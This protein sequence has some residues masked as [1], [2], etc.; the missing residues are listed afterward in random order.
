MSKFWSSKVRWPPVI[1]S[2]VLSTNNFIQSKTKACNV[3]ADRL[4]QLVEYRTTVRGPTLRVCF[5]LLLSC[6]HVHTTPNNLIS[7]SPVV[8]TSLHVHLRTKHDRKITNIT[9]LNYLPSGV[10]RN[11]YKHNVGFECNDFS[12]YMAKP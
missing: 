1:R 3:T 5:T 10:R 9:K 7:A 8:L 2:P 4:A 6:V 11:T 12:N